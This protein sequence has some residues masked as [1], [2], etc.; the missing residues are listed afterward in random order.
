MQDEKV[1]DINVTLLEKSGISFMSISN[2]RLIEN[3]TL[4]LCLGNIFE[5]YEGHR[6][7]AN[8]RQSDKAIDSAF[9]VF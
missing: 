7:Y 1:E 9:V 4:S 6:N 5:I 3:K 2:H 8:T